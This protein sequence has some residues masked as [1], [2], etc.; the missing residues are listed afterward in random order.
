MVMIILLFW[1]ISMISLL[2]SNK[3]FKEITNYHIYQN[4][5]LNKRPLFHEDQNYFY[6]L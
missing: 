4:V 5:G 2:Y 6:E 3:G 1:N